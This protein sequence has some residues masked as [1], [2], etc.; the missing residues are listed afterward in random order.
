MSLDIRNGLEFASE[1]ER[2]TNSVIGKGRREARRQYDE[3]CA[4]Y[5]RL[6]LRG[7]TSKEAKTVRVALASLKQE[8]ETSLFRSTRHL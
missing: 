4:E 8:I 1:I 5:N 6:G 2:Y 7:Q 3:Y